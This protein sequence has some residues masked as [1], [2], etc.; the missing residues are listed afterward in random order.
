MPIMVHPHVDV[1]TW[2]NRIRSFCHTC[3]IPFPPDPLLPLLSRPTTS[4]LVRASVTVQLP[5]THS[6]ACC[7]M[8]IAIHR[9]QYSSR[10]HKRDHPR[11]SG[12][13]HLPFCSVRRHPLGMGMSGNALSLARA[14]RNPDGYRRCP[15]DLAPHVLPFHMVLTPKSQKP[16]VTTSPPTNPTKAIRR[17]TLV[18]LFPIVTYKVAR[19][20]KSFQFSLAVCLVTGTL[21]NKMA[22]SAEPTHQ[23]LVGRGLS[24]LENR[25]PRIVIHFPLI[26]RSVNAK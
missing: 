25:F 23:F 22:K 17:V 1:P 13:L 24:H 18:P 16:L 6:I 4:L 9:D 10:S 8:A 7:V 20:R 15:W 26:S 3:S 5:I 21:S 19:R 11:P 2:G 12:V 14:G